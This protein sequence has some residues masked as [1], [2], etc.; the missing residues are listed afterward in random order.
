[1]QGQSA[2]IKH[3]R[4]AAEG[5]TDVAGDLVGGSIGAEDR[6]VSD[7]EEDTIS[8]GSQIDE[9]VL[10]LMKKY[11]GMRLHQGVWSR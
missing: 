6:D 4:I 3:L 9:E 8:A 2:W 10:A 11:H 1:M 7:E 5:P